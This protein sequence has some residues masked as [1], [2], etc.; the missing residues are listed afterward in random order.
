M[1]EIV[2]T[3][4]SGALLPLPPETTVT[5]P[6]ARGGFVLSGV[7]VDVSIAPGGS[8]IFPDNQSLVVT[9]PG[10]SPPF[11][12]SGTQGNGLAVTPPGGAQVQIEPP[13]TMGGLIL[14]YPV[15]SPGLIQ[16]PSGTVVSFPNSGDTI[17]LPG[18]GTV[19]VRHY[20]PRI[21][22]TG[23]IDDF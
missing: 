8:I 22:D 21:V 5:L 3:F 14:G 7:T 10:G 11:D 1:P 2:I 6:G 20:Q 23:S 16:F 13:A 15:L 12:I 4:P 9:L 18:P 19:S 17:T